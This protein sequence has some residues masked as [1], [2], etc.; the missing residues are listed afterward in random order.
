MADYITAPDYRSVGAP[1][2]TPLSFRGPSVCCTNNRLPRRVPWQHRS[3]IPSG[4]F[5]RGL[6]PPTPASPCQGRYRPH[7]PTDRGLSFQQ[8]FTFIITQG[9]RFLPRL[10]P[11]VSSPHSYEPT[12]RRSTRPGRADE[13]PGIDTIMAGSASPGGDPG[14]EGEAASDRTRSPPPP[15]SSPQ[16]Y[17]AATRAR[18]QVRLVDP[19]QF[20]LGKSRGGSGLVEIVPVDDPPVMFQAIAGRLHLVQPGGPNAIRASRGRRGC[21]GIGTISPAV[22][23]SC[24]GRSAQSRAEDRGAVAHVQQA[25]QGDLDFLLFPASALAG[26][27]SKFRSRSSG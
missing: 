17:L 9:R 24:P 21:R 8:S 22:R 2:S 7:Q 13:R 15:R 27:G 23:R 18:E 19:D 12:E 16:R 14:H 4:L 20:A 26:G 5:R 11:G 10:K 1:P 6:T 3:A 25:R